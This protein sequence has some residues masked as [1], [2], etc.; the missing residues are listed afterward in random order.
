M[1][2]QAGH[3]SS[4]ASRASAT[5]CSGS[6]AQRIESARRR[7]GAAEVVQSLGGATVL[8]SRSTAR[9]VRLAGDYEVDAVD[10]AGHHLPE[11]PA[12]AGALSWT[13]SSPFFEARPDHSGFAQ[14]GCELAHRYVTRCRSPP[15]G[16]SR[17]AHGS[18]TAVRA[19]S[20][21][22]PLDRLQHGVSTWQDLR[23]VAQLRAPASAQLYGLRLVDTRPGAGPHVRRLD[24][25]TERLY[26]EAE[27]ISLTETRLLEAGRQA[28]ADATTVRAASRR[29]RRR[30][31][32]ARSGGRYL[33]RAWRYRSEVRERGQDLHPWRP[34]HTEAR[35]HGAGL[36]KSGPGWISF[37]RAP[38]GQRPSPM[39]RGP[40]RAGRRRRSRRRGA[41][42]CRRG[43][44]RHLR[45]VRP[46]SRRTNRGRTIRWH[47]GPSPPLGGLRSRPA[48]SSSPA[49]TAARSAK[50][51]PVP[52]RELSAAADRLK[53]CRGGQSRPRASPRDSRA[54][55]AVGHAGGTC[56]SR[57]RRS[58]PGS[59]RHGRQWPSLREAAR[60]RDDVR[61]SA[62]SSL[63]STFH[64]AAGGA[65]ER[66]V[67]FEDL[68]P[69]SG[70]HQIV[71]KAGL[72]VAGSQGI[73]PELRELEAL[74]TGS[75]GGLGSRNAMSCL[76]GCSR[77]H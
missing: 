65:C 33:S 17:R 34:A 44:V 75:D 36:G 58:R 53:R 31:S 4:R 54:G 24:R 30:S 43:H 32:T 77:G 20:G 8:G 26:R 42:E 15:G 67:T 41:R 23:E 73:A 72:E 52:R 61:V 11:P 37:C 56:R 59:L 22:R 50:G 14:R 64:R 60:G 69:L 66:R 29:S 10:G 5:T 49:S 74:V 19:Q 9:R 35:E 45:I 70:R 25:R 28:L 7:Q 27:N 76:R 39:R 46:S 47:V 12:V 55:R 18:R 48:S 6:V 21:A 57:R 38:S 3:R 51:S 71:E 68:S 13:G 16:R 63:R 1:G 40:P 62:R 2:L